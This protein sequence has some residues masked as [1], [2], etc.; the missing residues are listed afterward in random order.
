MKYKPEK[1]LPD[2]AR[3]Y[4]TLSPSK[5]AEIIL[6]R[7]NKKVTPESITM[8]FKRHP[9]VYE[10]LSKEIVEGLP[11]EKEEVDVSIYEMSRFMEIPSVKE[12][13]LFMHTRRRKGKELHP[14]YITSQVR[15]LRQALREHSVPLHPDRLTFRDAQEIFLEMEKKGKDTYPFRRAIKDFLKSKGATGWEKI[16]VGKPKGFGKY[17]GLYV[18]LDT[19]YK[20]LGW[21]YT[22][23]LEVFTVDKIMWHNGIRLGAVLG[24]K[25]EKFHYNPTGF[26]ILTVLEKFREEK[27]FRVIPDV[28]NLIKEVIGDRKSGK[29]FRIGE[30]RVNVLNREAMRKFCPEL[31]PQ[32]EMPSH[33]FRHMFFQHLLRATNWNYAIVASIGQT[34]EQSLKESYGGIPSGDVLEWEKQYL[35]LLDPN[36]A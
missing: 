11:T 32:V 19:I 2:F 21:I 22:Q 33:F 26:S 20:M 14:E 6:N 1:D 27:T 17:R 18:D 16:G 7:R 5:L 36:K 4:K 8:W 31:E 34:T 13:I 28:A 29:I 3:E 23:D 9:D 15:L 12:W 30:R 25:I 24:A 10:Q 35:P